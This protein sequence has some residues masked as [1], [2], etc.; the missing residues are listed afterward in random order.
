[1]GASIVGAVY[2]TADDVRLQLRRAPLTGGIPSTNGPTAARRPLVCEVAAF[3]IVADE[4][5]SRVYF[6]RSSVWKVGFGHRR[7]A[8]TARAERCSSSVC[9]SVYRHKTLRL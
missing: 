4:V 9:M 6:L 2:T 3:P 8:P 7:A 1:M 5:D